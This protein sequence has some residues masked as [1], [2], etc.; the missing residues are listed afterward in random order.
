MKICF[1]EKGSMSKAEGK[2]SSLTQHS[3]FPNPPFTDNIF[4]NK[5]KSMFYTNY[6][7][8]EFMKIM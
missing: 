7:F 2:I 5:S 3:L 8:N 1:A 6:T 4:L